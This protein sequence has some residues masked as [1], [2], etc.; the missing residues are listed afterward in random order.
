MALQS[1]KRGAIGA[2]NGHKTEADYT[3]FYRICAALKPKEKI[4]GS[5]GRRMKRAKKL[6]WLAQKAWAHPKHKVRKDSYWHGENGTQIH[7]LTCP[8]APNGCMCS[9]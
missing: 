4:S 6:R 7:A 8:S 1:T 9:C 2:Q 3:I 5:L